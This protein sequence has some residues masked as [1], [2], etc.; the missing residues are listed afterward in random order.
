[1]IYFNYID[2]L[3]S[4]HMAFNVLYLLVNALEMVSEWPSRQQSLYLSE[5]HTFV[6]TFFSI[7]L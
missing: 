2:G 3:K 7:M 4:L 5:G 1:M 6:Y